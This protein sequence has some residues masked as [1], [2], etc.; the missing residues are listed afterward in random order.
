[1]TEYELKGSDAIF[2]VMDDGMR[3]IYSWRWNKVFTLKLSEGYMN[4]QTPEEGWRAQFPKHCDNENKDEEIK[5]TVNN[6]F[7]MYSSMFVHIYL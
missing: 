6:Y 5:L 2:I 4:W 7:S 3:S 1:M